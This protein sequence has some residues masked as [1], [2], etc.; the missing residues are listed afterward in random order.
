MYWPDWQVQMTNVVREAEKIEDPSSPEIARIVTYTQALF[1]RVI[2]HRND[3]RLSRDRI[4]QQIASAEASS[5]SLR[6]MAQKTLAGMHDAQAEGLRALRS[7]L[8]PER[9]WW[10]FLCFWQTTPPLVVTAQ[11]LT[12][13]LQLGGA[14]SV[15]VDEG[16]IGKL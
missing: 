6:R 10:Q 2:A 1:D 8:Y 11:N 4:D 14:V 3:P 13:L 7:E 5:L 12:Y 9:G 15:L 16:N